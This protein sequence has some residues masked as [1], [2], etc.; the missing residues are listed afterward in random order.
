MYIEFEYVKQSMYIK[1][2]YVKQSTYI[3][4]KWVF[5]VMLKKYVNQN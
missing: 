1:F 3:D 4:F 5:R 2:K